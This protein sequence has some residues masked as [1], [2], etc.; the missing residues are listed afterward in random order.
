MSVPSTDAADQSDGLR[1]RLTR[2]P[3]I[4]RQA[5]S[6]E[7]ASKKVM[8]LN[9]AEEEADKGGREKRTYGRTP[10]GTGG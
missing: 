10:D 1:E 6:A 5:V 9:S 3:E 7:A 2:E 8:E 4:S